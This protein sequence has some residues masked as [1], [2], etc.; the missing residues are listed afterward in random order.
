MSGHSKWHNIRLKKEKVDSKRGKMFTRVSKEI[1]LAVKEGGPDPDGNHRLAAAIQKAKEVNM[2]KTH[3]TRAIDKMTGDGSGSNIEEVTYEGYGPHGVAVLVETA[4]DNKNRTV[5][6][7][8][9]IFTKYGGAMGEAGCVAWIFDKKGL[10][11]VKTD[12]IGEDELFELIIDAGAEDLKRD[13]D[14]EVFEIYTEFTALSEVKK[15]LQEK[16]IP[17]ESSDIT[18]IPKNEVILNKSQAETVLKM[19]D[20]MEENDDVQDVHANFNI[21]EEILAELGA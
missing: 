12:A 9:N 5:P 3:I 21:P 10:I 20:L 4:T 8:R 19:M 16:N 15:Y 7:I 2:P 17:I 1:M 14:E 6:E 11:T 13:D 18:M